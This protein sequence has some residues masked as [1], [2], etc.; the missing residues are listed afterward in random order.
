M[1]GQRTV[2]ELA[3]IYDVSEAMMRSHLKRLKLPALG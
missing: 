3:D 2:H 1:L